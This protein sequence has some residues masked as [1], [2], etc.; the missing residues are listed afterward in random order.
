MDAGLPLFPRDHSV[1]VKHL[2]V[3][4][5]DGKRVQSESKIF[6]FSGSD[7]TF[8]RRIEGAI[9]EKELDRILIILSDSVSRLSFA[10]ANIKDVN[11]HIV[12]PF[13]PLPPYGFFHGV[14][15]NRVK[16]STYIL[17]DI[18]ELVSSLSAKNITHP[19]RTIS[20]NNPIFDGIESANTLRR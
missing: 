19:A 14:P 3:S 15:H 12:S 7:A 17:F 5:T 16:E 2:C 9:V 10:L 6:R 13:Y 4:Y 8:S 11:A 1:K 18:L 20:E